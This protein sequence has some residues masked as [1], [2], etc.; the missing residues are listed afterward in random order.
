MFSDRSGGLFRRSGDCRG[1]R[2]RR[3]HVTE[4]AAS[5]DAG[6]D[7]DSDT[8][9]YAN[10]HTDT[11]TDAHAYPDTDANAGRDDDHDYV[12]GSLAKNVDRCSW[13]TRNVHQQ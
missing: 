2:W 7:T 6:P 13:N 4:S 9:A 3:G 10:T 1:L 11:D 8:H 12:S 5:A